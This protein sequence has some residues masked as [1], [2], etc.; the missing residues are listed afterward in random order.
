MPT[1]ISPDQPRLQLIGRLLGPAAALAVFVCTANTL[2]ESARLTA[3]SGTLM[4][5]FWMTEAIPLAATALLPLALFPVLGILEIRQTAAPFATPVI[6][7][8]LGGFLIAAAV[9]RCGLHRRVALTVVRCIGGRS[10]QLLAGC[11]AATAF[12]SMWISNT[13]ATVMMLPIGISLAQMLREE[14]SLPSLMT[15]PGRVEICLLLGIAYAANIGGMGTIVGT[16]P[17]ALLAGFLEDRGI[18]IGFGRWMLFALPLV[19]L[20]LAS[21]WF[22]LYRFGFD[23]ISRGLKLSPE[24]ITRHYEKLG[25]MKRSEWTVLTV[26]V[27]TVILWTVREP[28]THWEWLTCYLPWIGGLND[29]SIAMGASVTLF[30]LP[31]GEA[32]GERVLDWKTASELPWGVLVL[33]GGGMSLGAAMSATGLTN[34]LSERLESLVHLPP[35]LLIVALTGTVIFLTEIMSN[36]AIMIAILPV[37]FG[38]GD[39]TSVGPLPLLVTATLAASC[40][41]MLPIGTPPNA[42]AYGTGLIPMQSMRRF[43]L[44]LNLI[45]TFLIPGLMYLLGWLLLG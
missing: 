4:V 8:F 15:K 10:G 5:V 17:N 22:V 45:G 34:A 18:A 13:A 9:E 23:R 26:F 40:A 20:L 43:G 25:H 16:P 38:I 6:F 27:A 41:F 11:M 37:L 35:L 28:L 21:C 12:L 24:A 29:V 42:C 44:W 14:N 31:S 7:L 2:P 19:A 33:I 39:Q 36:T 3:A 1:V 32:N 30:M